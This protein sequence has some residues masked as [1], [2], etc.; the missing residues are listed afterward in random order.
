MASG[1]I[2]DTPH[3][4]SVLLWLKT[5]GDLDDTPEPPASV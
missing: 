5:S 2:D 3:A 4:T 1:D